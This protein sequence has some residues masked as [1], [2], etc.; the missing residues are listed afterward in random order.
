[1]YH[2]HDVNLVMHSGDLSIHPMNQPDNASSHFM[3]GSVERG[4][5]TAESA[6]HVTRREAIL[7]FIRELLKLEVVQNVT[8]RHNSNIMDIVS[9]GVSN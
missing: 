9:K 7:Q 6:K 8:V 3:V 4:Q 5:V 2:L 1:M